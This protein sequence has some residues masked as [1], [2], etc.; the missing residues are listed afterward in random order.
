[1]FVIDLIFCLLISPQVLY[2]R[3]LSCRGLTLPT[4]CMASS[5]AFSVNVFR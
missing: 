1:M 2:W 3:G 5:K 4:P